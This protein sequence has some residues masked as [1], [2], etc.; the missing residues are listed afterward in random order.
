M[1]DGVSL[2]EH[3]VNYAFMRKMISRHVTKTLTRSCHGSLCCCFFIYLFFLVASK[4]HGAQAG[5]KHTEI[6]LFV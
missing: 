2:V 6:P 5:T 1:T 4:A 3:T